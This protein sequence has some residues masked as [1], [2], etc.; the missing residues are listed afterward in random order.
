MRNAYTNLVEKSEWQEDARDVEKELLY[1]SYL[2]R[3][4]DKHCVI[5]SLSN[6]LSTEIFR[7]KEEFSKLKTEAVGFAKTLVPLH[8]K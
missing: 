1:R 5:L 3:R 8:Q 7:Q 2:N 6:A 4:F